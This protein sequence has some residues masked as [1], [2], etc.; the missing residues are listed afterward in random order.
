LALTQ[1]T[2]PYVL[3]LAD[4][5]LNGALTGDPG[6][7][8]GLQVHA[9]KLTHQGLAEDIGRPWLAFEDIAAR[10]RTT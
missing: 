3:R 8:A 5:G 1:A 2:L 7:K 6:L 10:T 4:Q 9:G